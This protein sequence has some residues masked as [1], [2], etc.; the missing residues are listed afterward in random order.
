VELVHA[1]DRETVVPVSTDDVFM[2]TSWWTAH[3]AHAATRA[4]GRGRFVYLIQEYEPGFYPLGSQGA[5]AAESYN[6][7]H[8]ALFSTRLLRDHFRDQRVGVFAGPDGELDSLSFENA[9]TSVGPVDPAA[10]CHRPR[11]VLFYCRPELH[12]ARNLSEIGFLGLKQA[13]QNGAFRGWEFHGIGSVD[14]FDELELAE[15]VSLKMLPRMTQEEYRRLL[16]GYDVGIS[17]MWTPHPSLVPLEMAAAGL[18]TLTTTFAN[19]TAAALSAISANLI[20][21]EGTVSAVGQ[22]LRLAER[23]ARDLAARVKGAKVHWA[24]TWEESF[25]ESVL[26]GLESFF[27]A[28]TSPLV[29]TRIPA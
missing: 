27:R 17:L 2:A 13:I 19:K 4:I 25:P 11:R 24:T 16:P 6:F 23:R 1:Y 21:V 20:P 10:M 12:A 18:C 15:G 29:R 9:I 7:P 26:A 8:Y 28:T 3:V 22:G 14:V 5:F